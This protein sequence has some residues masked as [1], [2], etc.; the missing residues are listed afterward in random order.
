MWGEPPANSMIWTLLNS[1][2]NSHLF[3]QAQ[4]PLPRSLDFTQFHSVTRPPAA[5]SVSSVRSSD[6]S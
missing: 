1:H 2:T 5:S 3:S 4:K 6:P